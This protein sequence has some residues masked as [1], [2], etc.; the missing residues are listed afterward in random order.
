MILFKITN[1]KIPSKNFKPQDFYINGNGEL[2]Y[3]CDPTGVDMSNKR[4]IVKVD[5]K[6]F[7]IKM[8]K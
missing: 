4:R 3:D 2:F 8:E 1:T 7:I 5:Q 6:R